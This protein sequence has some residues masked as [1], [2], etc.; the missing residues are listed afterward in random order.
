MKNKFISVL[1]IPFLLLFLIFFS[2]PLGEYI[3]R[4]SSNSNTT[5]ILFT[6]NIFNIAFWGIIIF[7]F[8]ILAFYFYKMLGKESDFSSRSIEANINSKKITK[9]C[10][11]ICSFLIVIAIPFLFVSFGS[12]YEANENGFYKKELFKE[13]RLIFEYEDVDS[14]EVFLEWVH[15]GKHNNGYETFVEIKTDGSIYVLMFSGFSKDYYY[16]DSFLSNFED[17]IIT[18]DKTYS[19]NTEE[20]IGYYEQPETFEK[21]YKLE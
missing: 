8:I 3:L 4:L 20:I 11:A 9:N 17:K 14:V 5:Y 18:V 16:V 10:L 6:E 15:N 7:C 1:W 13:E 12:R 19:D 21:I 2:G